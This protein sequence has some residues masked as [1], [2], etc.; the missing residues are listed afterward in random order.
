MK[1]EKKLGELGRAIRGIA[2]WV[3]IALAFSVVV[4]F[5]KGPEQTI[6]YFGCYIIEWSL[7][8]DNLFVFL[9]IFMSFGIKNE[10]QHRVLNWGIAG[11]IV[12]RLLF[13]LFG[14]AVVRMFEWVLYVFG[15]I[16]IINGF[17]M[18]GEEKETDP[19]DSRLFKIIDK[20]LPMTMDYYG[21][22]F[23]VK[24]K[25]E[26]KHGIK[27]KWLFTPLFGIMVFIT[28]ADI[29]FAVDS[30]PAALSM[31][32]DIFIVYSSNMFA[33]LGLRQLFFVIEILNER[34]RYVK[35]GVGIILIF[36][37]VKLALLF[38]D[39]E[40]DNIISICTITG[41][42]VISIILSA[43]ISKKHE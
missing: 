29:I 28:F 40:I 6:D 8:I 26:T 22:K 42:L 34:F 7:S 43:I 35:Y 10:A 15:I 4:Y 39:F 37:G 3:S 9:L 33:V 17:K 14:I 19:H 21:N 13:I 38:I 18:F 5:Y 20:L 31:S 24:E 23:I 11:S 32:T 30:V 25:A 36:T 27:T 2:I 16:L 12:L 41:V 1:K